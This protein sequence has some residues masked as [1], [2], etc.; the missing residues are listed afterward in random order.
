MSIK[1]GLPTR[2]AP[3]PNG[4]RG[5]RRIRQIVKNIGDS[6]SVQLTNIKKTADFNGK[7]AIASELNLND[8]GDA[9]ELQEI[10]VAAKALLAQ[11]DSA[12]A[13]EIGDL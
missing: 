1:D 6:L 11:I 12:L 9:A 13:S 10:Y 8:P 4:K 3:T 2:P 5:A 7:A